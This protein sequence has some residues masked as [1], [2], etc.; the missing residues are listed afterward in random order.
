MNRTVSRWST[1]GRRDSRHPVD[2]L[3]RPVEQGHR[4]GAVDAHVGDPGRLS[5]VAAGQPRG[6]GVLI[7]IRLSSHTN[8]TG[9]G[10][11]RWARYDAAF[12][13]PVT[14]EWL[15]EASPKLQT[16]IASSGQG[17]GRPRQRASPSE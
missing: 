1:P 10:T 9:H 6:D 5:S 17:V 2:H 4:V 3:G 13:A 7:P 16:T 14:V 11:P 12:S 15:A 8:R